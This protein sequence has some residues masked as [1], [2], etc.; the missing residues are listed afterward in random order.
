MYDYFNI[1]Y[2]CIACEQL[3]NLQ[4]LR[5][6][7]ILTDRLAES[8]LDHYNHKRSFLKALIDQKGYNLPRHMT[9]GPARD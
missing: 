7:P 4:N 6:N 2:P 5:V 1:E 8:D 3:D 9:C